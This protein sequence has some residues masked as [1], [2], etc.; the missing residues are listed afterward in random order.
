MPNGM[1]D[2]LPEQRYI[3]AYRMNH[4]ISYEYKTIVH[5]SYKHWTVRLSSGNATG[6]SVVDICAGTDFSPHSG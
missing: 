4:L 5:R 6:K 1:S 3:M 2:V